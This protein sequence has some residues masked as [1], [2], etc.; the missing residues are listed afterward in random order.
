MYPVFE[1]RAQTRNLVAKPSRLHESF[2][3]GLQ[4]LRY[5]GAD[6]GYESPHRL[7]HQPVGHISPS[8]DGLLC[9]LYCVL[10]V[11]SQLPNQSYAMGGRA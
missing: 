2:H 10:D 3:T 9:C 8:F 5:R 6:V 1:N 4:V 11:T 7:P